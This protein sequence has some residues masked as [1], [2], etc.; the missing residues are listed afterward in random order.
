[1]S[2]FSEFS[3]L[4]PYVQ[5]VRKLKE[6]LVFDMSFPNDWKLPKKYV[7]E[8]KVVEV[9]SIKDRERFFHFVSNMDE[10]SV[11]IVKNNIIGIINYNIERE[12][13]EKLFQSK[14]DE[15]KSIFEKSSLKNLKTLKFDVKPKINLINGEENTV[16]KVVRGTEE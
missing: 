6:Y 12:E 2:L 7:Q 10:D 3:S 13:K 8:D 5:S 9:E 1:M 4:L 15:L 14:V 16:T 11:Q